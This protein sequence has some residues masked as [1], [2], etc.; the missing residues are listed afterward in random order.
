[1]PGPC[2]RSCCPHSQG[3]RLITWVPSTLLSLQ[4]RLI[5]SSRGAGSQIPRTAGASSGPHAAGL[6][7][8]DQSMSELPEEGG[9]AEAAVPQYRGAHVAG[10]G[11]F[12]LTPGY[13]GHLQLMSCSGH[14]AGCG[15]PACPLC[16][17]VPTW[18][19]SPTAPVSSDAADLLQAPSQPAAN[20][21][22]CRSG[23]AAL[24]C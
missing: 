2:S 9:T 11:P 1:M 22:R 15:E 3:C 7:D 12:P 23:R 24:E 17:E 16:P 5:W 13:G 6:G 4:D 8:E 18:C 19:P 14:P 20:R 10:P 21:G